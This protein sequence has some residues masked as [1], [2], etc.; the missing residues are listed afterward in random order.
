VVTKQADKKSKAQQS[1]AEPP[2]TLRW[3]LSHVFVLARQFGSK[4]IVASVVIYLIHEATGA[5]IAFAG[6][7]SVANLVMQVAGQF[8]TTVS[9]SLAVTGISTTLWFNEH[10]RHKNTR[11]RLTARITTLEER[12]NPNRTSSKLTSQGTTSPGDL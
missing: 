8:N 5:V 12:I 7:T 1:K 10:R 4:L 11:E 3:I 2:V 9:I 6:R